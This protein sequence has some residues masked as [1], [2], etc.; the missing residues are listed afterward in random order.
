MLVTL[1]VDS[2]GIWKIIS[3]E[4]AVLS[5][6]NLSKKFPNDFCI[7]NIFFFLGGGGGWVSRYAA[8]PIIVALFA[9]HSD[10]TRFNPWLPIAKENQLDRAKK[11]S[12][13]CSDAW[14]R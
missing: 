2:L 12:K 13:I 14:Q 11:I 5:R 1:R 3:D 7:R 8:I 9:G 4:N 10:I 6:N